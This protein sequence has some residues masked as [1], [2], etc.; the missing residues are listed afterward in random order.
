[1]T[2]LAIHGVKLNPKTRSSLRFE[3]AGLLIGVLAIGP[4]VGPYLFEPTDN[5]R[6]EPVRVVG[7]S[8]GIGGRQHFQVAST[9]SGK[10]WEVG[11][12]DTPFGQ[13]YRGLATLAFR[14]G[15]W[16]GTE[17]LRLYGSCPSPAT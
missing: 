17:H 5:E 13:G 9:L 8:Y 10:V 11:G 6:C 1:M 4:I 2:S 14:H 12:A 15:R 7:F 16:T 3:G